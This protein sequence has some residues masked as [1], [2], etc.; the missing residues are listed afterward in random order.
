MRQHG[1]VIHARCFSV[2]MGKKTIAFYSITANE[3]A[4]VPDIYS[5]HTV[6]TH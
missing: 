6:Q 4:Y 3:D 1:T 5:I 2:T